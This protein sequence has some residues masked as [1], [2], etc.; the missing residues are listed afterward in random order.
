MDTIRF[1]VS[2]YALW[3]SIHAIQNQ[4][5]EK[6]RYIVY[7]TKEDDGLIIVARRQYSRPNETYMTCSDNQGESDE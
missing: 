7:V 4:A 1:K 2:P 6:K 3:D 5:T